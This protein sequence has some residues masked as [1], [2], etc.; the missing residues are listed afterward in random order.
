MNLY[1]MLETVKN[2]LSNPLTLEQIWLDQRRCGNN[3]AGMFR[4]SNFSWP[5]YGV[6]QVTAN[7]RQICSVVNMPIF[8]VAPA[9]TRQLYTALR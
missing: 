6:S 5:A 7:S 3:W 4:K 9:D 1:P 2:T 8:P